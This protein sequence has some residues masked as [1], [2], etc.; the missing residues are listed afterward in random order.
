MAVLLACCCQFHWPKVSEDKFDKIFFWTY[1]GEVDADFSSR[2]ELG[3]STTTTWLR[4]EIGSVNITPRGEL[5]PD[6]V[7][8]DWSGDTVELGDAGDGLDVLGIV[9]ANGLRSFLGG[10]GGLKQNKLIFPT[11][12]N[13]DRQS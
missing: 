1:R 5:G 11:L 12:E 13:P 8:G 6:L 9:T 10:I 3:P 4:G 7:R 2:G